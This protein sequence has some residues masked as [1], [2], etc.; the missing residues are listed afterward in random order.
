MGQ[1]NAARTLTRE[2]RI[3]RRPEFLYIQQRGVRTRGRYMTLIGLSNARMLSRLGIVAPRRL[4]KAVRRNH[5]KRRVREFFRHNKPVAGLDL[6]VLPRREFLDAPFVILLDD[7]RRT[8]Q[9]QVRAHS[10]S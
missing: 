9:R 10:S 6:V 5:S 4:G 8:L 2:E 7:Y 1:P 3:R